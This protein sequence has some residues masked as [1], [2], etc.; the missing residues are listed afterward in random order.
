MASSEAEV[1]SRNVAPSSSSSGSSLIKVTRPARRARYANAVP[2]YI[3]NDPALNEAIALLPDNY[4]F[5]I[6]KSV[7]KVR[8]EGVQMVA[9]QFPEGLLMYACVISD[10]MRRFGGVKVIILGDVTYGACCIDDFTA[11]KLG[12]QLLVHY[13]HSCLVPINTTRIKVLYV[14]VEIQFDCSHLEAVLLRNF[15]PQCRL[16][17]MGTIQFTGAIHKALQSLRSSFPHM[18]VPQAKPLS[19]GETLGCTSPKL[20][21]CEAL[22]F[23][24]DGRFH[25]EAAMIQNPLV[26][27]FRYDPYGKALTA[28]GY[29]SVLL[30]KNRWTHIL[31]ARTAKRFGLI[32]GTLG[33][34]GNPDVYRRTKELLRKH[35]RQHVQFLMAEIVPQKLFMM[36]QID[37]WVQVACPRL[38]IDWGS[39]LPLPLLTPYELQVVLG[40][41]AWCGSEEGGADT[42]YPMDYYAASGGPWA[43]NF[44]EVKT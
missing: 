32:L 11:Q 1:P 15:D 37:A 36:K 24:A 42:A 25:L 14:F 4:N 9:L 5:E 2:D 22:V 17:L 26:K 28:E 40:E 8:S 13:G 6:H 31:Q 33:R 41:T 30:K 3:L 43:N 18:L 16:A 21:D 10:I 44:K 38:S 27:A 20:P 35:G 7:W 12:A 39:D 29:D 23:V 19:P 34:Q